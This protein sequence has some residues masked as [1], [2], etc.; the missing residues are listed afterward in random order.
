MRVTRLMV[1]VALML[2]GSSTAAAAALV[3]VASTGNDS[4]LVRT[5]PIKKSGDAKHWKAATSWRHHARR[6]DTC[7]A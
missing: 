2:V 4:E 1:L 5:V 6:D 7:W 3:D